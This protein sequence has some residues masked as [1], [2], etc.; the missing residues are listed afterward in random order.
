MSQLEDLVKETRAAFIIAKS[1]GVLDSGE[2]IQIAVQLAQKINKL[3]NLSGSE[4][5]SILLLALKKGLDN[6]G[7][8]DSLTAFVNVTPEVKAAFETQ[9]LSSA[10]VSI[11]LILSAASGT[12]DLKKPSSWLKFLPSCFNVVKTLLPKDQ[13]LVNEAIQYADSVINKDAASVDQVT[14]IAEPAKVEVSNV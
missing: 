10:S 6:A 8:L 12:L 14:V 5:K 7:G 9:L 1:D 11:D 13:K 3:S 2:V 4:K